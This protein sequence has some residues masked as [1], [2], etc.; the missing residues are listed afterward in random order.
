MSEF[1]AYKGHKFTIEW[2]HDKK[3]KSQP[4][5]Y[6]NNLKDSQKRKLLQL[7]KLIGDF[8]Q[9]RNKEKFNFEGDRI[10]AFKPQPDRFLCFFFEGEKNN[11]YECF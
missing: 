2:Y 6:F 10:Y 5:N 11:R 3:G 8:G 4:L 1:V 7:F 9:I